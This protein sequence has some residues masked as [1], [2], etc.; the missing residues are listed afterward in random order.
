MTIHRCPEFSG[1]VALMTSAGNGIGC[2]TK[3]TFADKGVRAVTTDF[4]EAGG[5]EAVA[6]AA[7]AAGWGVRRYALGAVA[8]PRNRPRQDCARSVDR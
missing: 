5:Q 2:A 1:E 4:N 3:I 7:R 6:P 8:H